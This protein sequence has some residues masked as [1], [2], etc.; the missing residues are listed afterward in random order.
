[1]NEVS[2][3]VYDNK[4]N[5]IFITGKPRTGKSTMINEI[6]QESGLEAAGLRAPEIR[7]SGKRKGFKLV[8]VAT[9]EEGILSHV[10]QEEGPRVSRYRVDMEDLE[11]FTKFSLEN[12]PEDCELLII[13]E[14]GTMEL[15]SDKFKDAVEELL[16]ADKPVIAVLHRNYV[17]KYEK[18]GKV[19][20]LTGGDYGGVKREILAELE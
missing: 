18:Y 14:I 2:K 20:R 10:D 7:E 4:Y 15:F 9:G 12:I 1:M 19:Y 3:K 8:D 13:D 11:R 16:E 5:N 6:I 17:D